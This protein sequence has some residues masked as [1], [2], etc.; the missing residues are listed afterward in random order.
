[1]NVKQFT[2][3]SLNYA[4]KDPFHQMKIITEYLMLKTCSAFNLQKTCN[5]R[6]ISPFH[7]INWIRVQ[8]FN[9]GSLRK[10]NGQIV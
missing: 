1:M 5:V 8:C 10:T 6:L 2:S 4:F 3:T 7:L 9:D